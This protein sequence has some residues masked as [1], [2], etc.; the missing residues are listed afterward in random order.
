MPAGRGHSCD[1]FRLTLLQCF[2]AGAEIGSH[3]NDHSYQ[4]VNAGV[5]GVLFGKKGW[6]ACEELHLLDAVEVFGF[7]NWEDISQKIKTR[8]PEEAKDQ[9]TSRYL[10]GTIGRLTWPSALGLRPNLVDAANLDTGPLSPTSSGRLPPLDVTPDEAK[11]LVYMPLRDDFD[12]EFDNDAESLLS[13]LSITG[14]DDDDLDLALTLVQV[15]IYTHRLRERARRKRVA[16]DYQLVSQ[17]YNSTS[18]KEKLGQ[19]KKPTR[20]EREFQEGM[21]VFSQFHTAQ[22]HE[23]FVQNMQREQELKLRLSEL[24][25]YRQHGITRHE[26]CSHFEQELFYRQE[27]SKEHPP[28]LQ[29]GPHDSSPFSPTSLNILAK[30]RKRRRGRLMFNRKKMHIRKF[31]EPLPG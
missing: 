25:R 18:R 1:N 15:D 23:Q 14:P 29:W 12:K 6:S 5:V 4:F 20:D 10:E 24:S 3:R 27:M 26:E 19:K 8:T 9:Y 17:F 7:G 22:E 21:R 30:K 2:S 16:R 13:P 11:Q 28:S 31:R